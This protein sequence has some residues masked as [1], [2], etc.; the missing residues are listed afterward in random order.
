MPRIL[1]SSTKRSVCSCAKADTNEQKFERTFQS[2]QVSGKSPREF[3]ENLENL[4][5][6][7]SLRPANG[8][9]KFLYSLYPAENSLALK[10]LRTTPISVPSQK[11]CKVAL[12]QK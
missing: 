10:I 8:Q 4:L 11:L 6:D 7:Y 3:R 12:L 9:M 1:E 2:T 5:E